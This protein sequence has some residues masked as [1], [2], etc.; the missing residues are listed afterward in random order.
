MS[1]KTWIYSYFTKKQGFN[2]HE[3]WDERLPAETTFLSRDRAVYSFWMVNPDLTKEKRLVCHETCLP[4]VTTCLSQDRAVYSFQS[5]QHRL[6]QETR[7]VCHENC[8]PAVTTRPSQ[9]RAVTTFCLV[10]TD[11]MKKQDLPVMRLVCLH[12]ILSFTRQGCFPTYS[13]M[14]SRLHEQIRQRRHE[15]WLGTVHQQQT[16][17]CL[18]N[19]DLSTIKPVWDETHLTT[20]SKKPVCQDTLNII[21]CLPIDLSISVLWTQTWPGI[22]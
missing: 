11:L 2:C 7:L 17:F 13:V 9:D 21:V 10:N 20:S 16:L 14:P 8:Q 3:S 5:C 1:A 6:D 12:N 22:C 18:V 19:P 15:S 4:A